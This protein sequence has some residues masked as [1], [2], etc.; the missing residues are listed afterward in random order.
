MPGLHAT[1]SASA[2]PQ[3]VNCAGRRWLVEGLPETTNEYAAEGTALHSLSEIC[4][5][6][7]RDAAEFI[8]RNFAV[9]E[10]DFVINDERADS[11]QVYIELVRIYKEQGYDIKLETRLDALKTL[12][13]DMGGTSDASGYNAKLKRLVVI[14]A[15]FGKGLVEV[16]NNLQEIIYVIG[17]ILGEYADV[18]IAEIELVIVQPRGNHPEGPVR[19]W[20]MTPADLMDWMADLKAA[21]KRTEDKNA[22]R[23]AGAWCRWCPAAGFCPERKGLALKEAQADFTPRGDVVLTEPQNYKPEEFAKLLGQIDQIEEWC[24]RVREFA[25]HEAEAGRIPPGYKLV[26]SR[27]TRMWKS[28]EEAKQFLLFYGCDEADLYVVKEPKFKSPAQIEALIGKKSAGDVK[29]LW[30]SVSSGTVLVPLSDKR[31]AVTNEAA[32]EFQAREI[33]A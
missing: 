12:H 24:R 18:P 23:T 33:A 26:G 32:R 7:G 28:E 10:H 14:D 19:R 15:K 2:A 1:L 31:P 21:A 25:H 3:W 16:K 8:D 30:Q 4:L 5:R 29:H 22:P 11:V 17:N 9:G 20:V 13:P 27:P 6:E